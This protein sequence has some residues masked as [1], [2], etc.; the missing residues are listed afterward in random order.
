MA[1]ISSQKVD[2]N[3]LA[4]CV[5][6]YITISGTGRFKLKLWLAVQLMKLAVHICGFQYE[7]LGKPTGD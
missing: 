1:T 6:V 4:K 5:T 3:Q 7:I 2:I